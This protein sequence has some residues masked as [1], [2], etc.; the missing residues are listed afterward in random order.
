MSEL[1]P[2]VRHLVTL[3]GFDDAAAVQ[4]AADRF[5]RAL[6][7]LDVLIIEN[8][9]AT[10]GPGHEVIRSEA[11]IGYAAAANR[12]IALAFERNYELVT[13]A[14]ADIEVDRA[15]WIE[16]QRATR[17]V[18]DDVA[19]LGGVELMPGGSV[20][21]AGGR[22]SPVTGTDHWH[23]STPD[24]LVTVSFVQG[25]FVSFRPAVLRTGV[26]FDERLFMYFDEIDLGLRLRC[27]GLRCVVVP[28]VRY[29]HDNEHGRYRPFRGYLM[30][31]NR[32]MVV[33]RYAGPW[34]A[35]AHCWGLARLL[36]GAASRLPRL[37]LDYTRASLHGWADGVRNRTVGAERY[38]LPG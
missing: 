22:W 28:G 11:N 36:V 10:H 37:Q 18:G 30:H 27:N 8:G 24:D 14:N 17:A 6:P 19:V 7:G 12:A 2:P 35:V 15:S 25:A 9:T 33:N 20:R 32:A 4:A 16:L 3:I 13:I 21:S 23:R 26:P 34:R 31:R 38:G 1:P 5:Q 29:T